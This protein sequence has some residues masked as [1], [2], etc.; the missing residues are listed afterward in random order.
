MSNPLDTLASEA[1]VVQENGQQEHKDPSQQEQQPPSMKDMNND[2]DST[3]LSVEEA[4]GGPPM[5]PAGQQGAALK[6]A[7]GAVPPA[8]DHLHIQSPSTQPEALSI[9]GHGDAAMAAIDSRLDEDAPIPH[10]NGYLELSH[11]S[12]G[13]AGQGEQGQPNE[14]DY[15]R[16][17]EVAN[18]TSQDVQE[19]A[20]QQEHIP[21]V[22]MDIEHPQGL[23]EPHLPAPAE[24]DSLGQGATSASESL[25]EAILPAPGQDNAQPLSEVE[26]E[27]TDSST[28]LQ[29]TA[30]S[31]PQEAN[32]PGGE[33]S[34]ASI[35][36]TPAPLPSQ[37]V[38]HT[39]PTTDGTQN[40]PPPAGSEGAD[41]SQQILE[42]GSATSTN[43]EQQPAAPERPANAPPA[44]LSNLLDSSA[45][46]PEAPDAAPSISS[47]APVPSPSLAK[48]PFEETSA[49]INDE[50]N[51]F[52]TP[53]SMQEEGGEPSSKRQRVSP[54]AMTEGHSGQGSMQL[55][56]QHRTEGSSQQGMSTVDADGDADAEADAE[57]DSDLPSVPSKMEESASADVSM[58]DQ[59]LDMSTADQ[60]ISQDQASSTLPPIPPSHVASQQETQQSANGEEFKPPLASSS[61]SIFPPPPP[62]QPQQPAAPATMPKEQVKYGLAILRQLKKKNEAGPFLQ[63]VDPVALG[64][65]HYPD[66]VTKPMDLSTVEK[67]LT[68][69]SYT[70]VEEFSSD[71]RQIWQNCYTFNGGDSPLSKWANTLSTLFERQLLKMPTLASIQAAAQAAAVKRSESPSH[72]PKGKA[73]AAGGAAAG[74]AGAGANKARRTSTALGGAPKPQVK[75]ENAQQ[76]GQQPGDKPKKGKKNQQQSGMA[77][78]GSGSMFPHQ[79]MGGGAPGMMGPTPAQ[80][81]AHQQQVQQLLN[82]EQLSFCKE[83]MNELWKKQYS[84]FVYPFYEPV[85]WQALGLPDYPKI[86]K[87]P[88]DLRTMRNKLNN[89]SYSNARAFENDFKLL[90]QNCTTYNPP[91][92]PV[93]QMGEQLQALFYEKWQG[94]PQEVPGHLMPPPPQQQQQQWGG[95]FYGGE[96]GNSYE[97]EQI[98]L[99]QRQLELLTGNLEMLKSKAMMKSSGGFGGGMPSPMMG[100]MG[101]MG[102]GGMPVGG[103]PPPQHSPG[104]DNTPYGAPPPAPPKPRP[105]PVARPPPKPAAPTKRRSSASSYTPAAA[106]AAAASTSLT[107]PSAPK[108]RTTKRSSMAGKD[109]DYSPPARGFGRGAASD[110]D[111]DYEDEPEAT[112]TF[113]MKKELADK[114]QEFD[115]PK[116]DKVVDIIRS[117]APALLGDDNQEIELDIDMLDQRTLL[118]LY[119]YV[120]KPVGKGRQLKPKKKKVKG[121]NRGVDEVAEEERINA[122][123]AQL[124]AMQNNV[125]V[126]QAGGPA[127]MPNLGEI[128]QQA[129]ARP[130]V[131]S[132]SSED[133]DEE[134]GSDSESDA[135]NP[136]A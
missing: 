129:N 103:A 71:M 10:T 123:Q 9:G 52:G 4:A 112:V 124:D 86:I 28:A 117:N 75:K 107:A 101:Q 80:Q 32:L 135:F 15:Q 79:G 59:S 35:P 43:A 100:G 93:H 50:A 48:R 58:I 92:T 98:M 89:G 61:S 69:G 31:A 21:P 77:Q 91:M 53:A 55:D 97:S 2:D 95:G 41:P 85:D 65:P 57:G 109:F 24:S 131:A 132:S 47:L 70:D 72:Q 6:E 108:P 122:L 116:L 66:I 87:R 121:R 26:P 90:I 49:S 11:Q 113:D 30:A 120:V 45:P 17:V 81:Q 22:S 36:D 29:E 7:I 94:M 46:T 114:I 127:V 1:A 19:G 27:A 125:A 62:A 3:P 128:A 111:S 34:L 133:E 51:Y 119:E 73:S 130:D 20:G 64:I 18:S 115:G 60:S 8:G 63:P 13:A 56:G 96:G 102:M 105:A 44:S 25:G 68:E 39:A 23:E 99:M 67:K 110:H 38:N 74:Q 5:P 88:I 126:A 40:L 33:T 42:N 134:D 83:V 54:E 104:V 76:A 16:V 12:N 106:A 82:H 78:D 14:L 84:S 118:K 136:D 37:L